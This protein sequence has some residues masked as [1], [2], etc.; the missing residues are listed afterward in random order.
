MSSSG[1]HDPAPQECKASSVACSPRAEEI[2]GKIELICAAGTADPDSLTSPAT[3]TV[4]TVALVSTG[5]ESTSPT[6]PVA[7]PLSPPQPNADAVKRVSIQKNAAS[8]VRSSEVACANTY[9]AGMPGCRRSDTSFLCRRRKSGQSDRVAGESGRKQGVSTPDSATDGGV[10]SVLARR[11]T[12]QSASDVL[13]LDEG[14]ANVNGGSGVNLAGN[15]HASTVSDPYP[16]WVAFSPL[17]SPISKQDQ[18]TYRKR[19][20]S[21][22]SGTA[23]VFSHSTPTSSPSKEKQQQPASASGSSDGSSRTASAL[24]Q[25]LSRPLARL[26]KTAT[27]A[28]SDVSRASAHYLLAQAS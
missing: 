24:K 4:R 18:N 22:G 2:G 28:G 17:T 9:A 15:L 7:S 5:E 10:S 6:A 20:G 16:A 23:N 11:R 21:A 3:D 12:A 27:A 19:A 1:G 8:A 13:D 25:L 26:K 14:A